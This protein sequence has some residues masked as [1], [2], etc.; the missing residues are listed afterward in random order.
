MHRETSLPPQFQE[1]AGKVEYVTKVGD[2][3]Y[4]SNCPACGGNIH[5]DG[6]FPDRFQMFVCSETT[7]GPL[8]WCSRCNF[9]WTPGKG[10]GK[11]WKPDPI[12]AA[13]WEQERR[14]IEE[15]RL[16]EVPH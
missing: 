15:R 8:G 16:M 9:T 11:D 13:A 6:Q 14:S 10:K 4:R 5:P 12:T 2:N 3:H 7:G 1:L